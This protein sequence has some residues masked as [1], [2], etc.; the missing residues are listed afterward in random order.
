MQSLTQKY[1]VLRAGEPEGAAA[2]A[3]RS[4][5][6]E[7]SP[8]ENVVYFGP[9]FEPFLVLM[10]VHKNFMEFKVSSSRVECRLIKR[11]ETEIS[12]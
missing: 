1:R 2:E 8:F 9:I 11:D 3:R 10:V 4:G 6:L 12:T 7:K 5:E